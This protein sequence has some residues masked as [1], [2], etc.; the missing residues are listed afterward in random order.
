MDQLNHLKGESAFALKTNEIQVQLRRRL[1]EHEKLLRAGVGLFDSVGN[2]TRAQWRQFVAALE[3][4]QNHPG[5]QGVGF[6]IWLKSS[7][8]QANLDKIRAEGF[9]EYTIT[10]EGERP[11]YAPIVYLEPFNWRNQRSF[12]FDSYSEENRR[13]AIEQAIN[14]GVGS[15]TSKIV[16]LQET[17]VNKQNGILM[18][19]PVYH[20]GRALDSIENRRRAIKGL[21]YSPIRMNDF[22]FATIGH[23]HDDIAIEIID[24]RG[25]QLYASSN[26]MAI[27][28]KSVDYKSKFEKINSFESFYGQRWRLH[29]QSLPEFES[30][31]L[32]NDAR[33]VLVFGLILS[34]LLALITY[35]SLRARQT[36]LELVSI[37]TRELKA[38][39]SSY[40]AIY[41]N[42]PLGIV[43]MN[44]NYRYISVNPAFEQIVGFSEEE[45]R[46]KTVFDRTH[47][48]D[49]ELTKVA[50]EAIPNYTGKLFRIEKRYIHKNGKV[51]WVVI[52][53]RAVRAEETGEEILYSIIEDVTERRMAEEKLRASEQKLQAVLRSSEVGIAWANENSEI[54]FVNPKFV[55]LFGY[56]L[57]EIPN[58]EQWY[59]RA[60]PD[61]QYRHQVVTEWYARI[62]RSLPAK[63]AIEPIEVSITCKDG[64]IRCVWL[65]GSWFGNNILANFSDITERK[66]METELIEARRLA[67]SATMAKSR[68]LA[69]MS[70]EIRTP[71]NG[72]LGMAQLVAMPNVEDT[73]RQQYAQAILSSGNVLLTL[74]NDILDFSKV[75]AG[76]IELESIAVDP[77]QIIQETQLLFSDLARQ[78]FL[79]I[80]GEWFGPTGQYYLSDPLR[81]R[82]M[83]SNLISNALKF[84]EKGKVRIEVHERS[85]SE[86]TAMLEFSVSD[87]GI[88]IPAEKL[89]RLFEPFSQSDKSTSRKYGGTGLGLSIVASLAKMMGGEVGAT[90]EPNLGSRFWFSIL[91]NY[92][93]PEQAIEYHRTHSVDVL[94]ADKG[95]ENSMIQLSGRVL[96]VDDDFI[97][98]MV[99]EKFLGKFG[100]KPTIA[101]NGHQALDLILRG[102]SFD[103]ILM[104]LQMPIMDGQVTTQQIR[105]WEE[106]N[107]HHRH[108]II[109][110]TADAFEETRKN[111]LTIGMDGVLIKPVTIG[112]LRELLIQVL[113]NQD[114]KQ[115]PHLNLPTISFEAAP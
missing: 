89:A 46:Q 3:L 30:A 66:R 74:L 36:A 83:L 63:T 61:P 79:E 105:K 82:Q 48:D 50:F 94:A 2:V 84:T 90:S 28:G 108:Q 65:V 40:R 4:D 77:K 69:T 8:K 73:E 45:L 54:E 67:E 39:E 106:E 78:K 62:Q 58:L 55:S 27:N 64:S 68:F 44:S 26:I 98:R 60:Y 11:V 7:E 24:E 80:E 75:E 81:L 57:D 76:K 14:L 59:Q 12:G 20:R 23:S 32:N 100:I 51:V 21:I 25:Q 101:E 53:S 115:G 42:S 71:M 93:S 34:F 104:D 1:E 56:T 70:H 17:E 22:I 15:I 49:R 5:I 29:S 31:V 110:F 6:S 47:A 96:V 103:L 10:P 18:Y 112:A 35:R 88:G 111:C 9:P 37:K 33:I 85:H 16:L 41:D 109:A 114:L 113:Q 72:I 87:T 19:V 38:R 99:I 102:K 91:A 97:N 13:E 86:K 43:Q 92:A 52:S 107:H 95:C